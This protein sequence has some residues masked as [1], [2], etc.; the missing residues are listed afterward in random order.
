LWIVPAKVDGTWKTP[1]GELTLKQT[2]Q[3]LTG[4]LRSGN[5]TTPINGK[6]TGDQISFTAGAAQYSGRVNGEAMAGAV[7]G[8]DGGN[9]NA[10]RAK[11]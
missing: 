8:G 2:F 11:R 5:V 1:Q 6:M 10:T 4:T 3:M 9:W 7:K